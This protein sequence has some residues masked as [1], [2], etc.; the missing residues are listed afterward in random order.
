M[1]YVVLLAAAFN[2]T[3]AGNVGIGLAKNLES[4]RTENF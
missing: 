2:V 3:D 1:A 4:R